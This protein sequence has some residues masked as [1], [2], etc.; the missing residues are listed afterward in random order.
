MQK[1]LLVRLSLLQLSHSSLEKA[2]LKKKP[3]L[4]LVFCLLATDRLNNCCSYK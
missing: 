4:G 2:D 3:D 1:Y